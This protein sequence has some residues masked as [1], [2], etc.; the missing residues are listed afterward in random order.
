MRPKKSVLSLNTIFRVCTFWK[1]I[2]NVCNLLESSGWKETGGVW[3]LLLTIS[4]HD[5]PTN[6]P[7][8][9]IWSWLIVLITES[10]VNE[11]NWGVP[12]SEFQQ[13][14]SRLSNKN[15]FPNSLTFLFRTELTLA[16]NWDFSDKRLLLLL[17]LLLLAITSCISFVGGTIIVIFQFKEIRSKFV[18]NGG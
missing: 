16:L 4:W 12:W 8:N 7:W 9:C 6:P 14:S 13:V 15:F 1:S 10:N 2:W 5:L 3:S 11:I 17:L 18:S